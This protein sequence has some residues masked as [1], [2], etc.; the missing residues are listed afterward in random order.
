MIDYMHRATYINY[1][2]CQTMVTFPSEE[3]LF[4]FA[5]D[6]D[7]RGLEL[8]EA[9]REVLAIED[10]KIRALRREYYRNGKPVIL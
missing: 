5:L 10:G 1:N 2:G 7:S 3:A 9:W 6:C 8:V 4:A